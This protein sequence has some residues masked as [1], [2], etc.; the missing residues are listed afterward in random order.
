VNPNE[1]CSI[2]GEPRSAHLPPGETHPREARGEGTHE[3]VSAGY[4]HGGGAWYEDR[5]VPP[6]YRFVPKPAPA[7]GTT[8]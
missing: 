5:Y 6:V 4:T 1:V 8:E 2:C 7:S 3:L